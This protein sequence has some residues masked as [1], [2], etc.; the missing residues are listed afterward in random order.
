MAFEHLLN[1][2][3]ICF[4]A[5]DLVHV[6]RSQVFHAAHNNDSLLMGSVNSFYAPRMA[7]IRQAL[8]RI[9]S[10]RIQNAVAAWRDEMASALCEHPCTCVCGSQATDNTLPLANAQLAAAMD[11]LRLHDEAE[12]QVPSQPADSTS[13][14]HGCLDHDVAGHPHP[15]VQK[16]VG[17]A[18]QSILLTSFRNCL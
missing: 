12:A 16:C 14:S 17:V 1:S 7:Y 4:Y 8:R 15:S 5:T 3:L 6:R 13:P 10:F 18:A 9:L 2:R 11:D